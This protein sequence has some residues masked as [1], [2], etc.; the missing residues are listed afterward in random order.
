MIAAIRRVL[1]AAHA[2]NVGDVPDELDEV[3]TLAESQERAPEP[4]PP[5]TI[6]VPGLL[7]ERLKVTAPA[8]VRDALRGGRTIRRGQGYS[9]RVIAP[10]ALHQS[11]LQQ[12]AILVGA[13][14]APAGRKAYRAYG[15]RIAAVTKKE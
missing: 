11:V 10:L 3:A 9:V 12:C 5:H 13:V 6:D 1:S 2:R 15:H 7:A 8:E 4:E 14:S